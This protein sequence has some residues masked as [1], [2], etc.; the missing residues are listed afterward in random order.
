MAEQAWDVILKGDPIAIELNNL[1]RLSAAHAAH[2]CADVV[3]QA[4]RSA[5]IA[6]IHKSHRL[7]HIVRDTMVV[8]QHASLSEA[9][10]DDAG[11]I[12]AGAGA[13]AGYP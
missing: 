6:A 8:T 10:F 9:I 13:K 5:G 7:Q 4:Y 1:L 12:L 11:A 2:S 3:Q